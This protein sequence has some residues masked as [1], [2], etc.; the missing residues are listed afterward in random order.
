MGKA[1]ESDNK[2]LL[3]FAIVSQMAAWTG[4]ALF[5]PM[6]P[7]YLRHLNATDSEIGYYAAA[8]LISLSL[9]PMLIGWLSDRWGVRDRLVIVC[10]VIQVPLAYSMGLT[11]SLVVACLLNIGLWTFGAS[12][13]NLT[14]AIV[15]LNFEKADRDRA[16]A[17]LAITSPIS[18]V[19]GG[20]AGGRIVEAWGYPALFQIMAVCWFLA[21]VAWLGV[22]DRHVPAED[23]PTDRAPISR[24]LVLFCA[25]ISIQSIAFQWSEIALPL[26]LSDLGF[27]LPFIT[28]MYS[29][30]NFVSI[31]AVILAGRYAGRVGNVNLLVGGILLFAICRFGLSMFDSRLEII[32]LQ[33]MTGLP[34]AFVHSIAAAVIAG[35]GSDRT[36]GSRMALL[37][38]CGGVG[39]ALGG[40]AGG[41]LL[42]AFGASGLLVCSGIGLLG[43][44]LFMWLFVGDP[45]RTEED[46]ARAA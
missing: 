7:L 22:R 32:G 39:G 45:T 28:S 12:T 38:M 43:A 36:V 5:I 35:L 20:L 8:T 18:F 41:H 29:V 26:R 4:A 27:S 16:F 11:Q 9:G 42:S 10:Y 3:A 46:Y 6:I 44:A 21:G 34:A 23:V 13:I 24:P 15:A 19:I 1:M 31:P 2:R 40:L 17:R 33:A 30:S 14:R 37:M 25:A